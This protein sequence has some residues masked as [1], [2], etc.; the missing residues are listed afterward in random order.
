MADSLLRTDLIPDE[1][2]VDPEQVKIIIETQFRTIV[3]SAQKIDRIVTPGKTKDIIEVAEL[4]EQAIR[5]YE[6]RMHT[7]EEGKVNLVY[8][9]PEKE[10]DGE[11]IAISFATRVPGG[12]GQGGPME[13]KT[14]NLRPIIRDIRDDPDAPGYKRVVL[15]YFY[16]NILRLTCW[17]R[18]NKAANARA[19][20]LENLM[21]QYTS[22]FVYSG[23][24]RIFYDGWK[25]PVVLDINN[26][27]Y[28][29]RPIDFYVKTE[30]LHNLSQKTL[31]EIYVRLALGSVT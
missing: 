12:I 13:S 17:A 2:L 19:I 29:G 15:G 8:E 10:F 22:W 7:T 21:E 23:V 26:Q 28:Y 25:T 9:R 5:D 31:E 4:I 11:T 6:L 14:K 20:W 16:D 24:N 18:T 3:E 30:K 27:R 1:L